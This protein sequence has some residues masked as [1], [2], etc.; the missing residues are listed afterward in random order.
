MK[1]LALQLILLLL[2]NTNLFSQTSTN[3]D[4]D[5]FK[6]SPILKTSDEVF[7]QQNNIEP[8]KID[9]DNWTV[10]RIVGVASEDSSVWPD[11]DEITKYDSITPT[12]HGGSELFVATEEYAYQPIN[13][14]IEASATF[15]YQNAIELVS[16]RT[17]IS[18]GIYTGYRRYWYVE[19]NFTSGEF[20]F[21]ARYAQQVG[22]D[23][24]IVNLHRELEIR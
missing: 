17:D 23:F 11:W 6:L 21:E 7:E 10:V 12:D 1:T 16:Q 5:Y 24:Q 19:R 14:I 15:N 13:G 18:N 4:L 22:S 2:L 9:S 20:K 3:L 8:A